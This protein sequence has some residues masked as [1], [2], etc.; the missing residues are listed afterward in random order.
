M[1]KVTSDKNND[2]K[3][4]NEIRHETKTKKEIGAE[5]KSSSEQSSD[6]K[7]ADKNRENTI[8]VDKSQDDILADQPVSVRDKTAAV[9]TS[10]NEASRSFTGRHMLVVQ[11]FIGLLVTHLSSR[12]L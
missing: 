8:S 10:S 1:H 6:M 9:K 12:T 5:R 2:K 11:L 4:V 3:V 7:N